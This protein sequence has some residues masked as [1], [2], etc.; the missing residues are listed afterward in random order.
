MYR[1]ATSVFAPALAVSHR[2][3][4][5]GG[6]T[7]PNLSCSL[8]R[9]AEPARASVW[10]YTVPKLSCSLPRGA[11]PARANVW[12]YTVS[13]GWRADEGVRPYH[14]LSKVSTGI[15]DLPS[16]DPRRADEERP[17]HALSKVS[18][19]K[20]LGFRVRLVLFLLRGISRLTLEMTTCSLSFIVISTDF[21]G[22]DEERPYLLKPSPWGRDAAVRSTVKTVHR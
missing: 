22:A 6:C 3:R 11:E 17:Y 12:G 18:T 14:A 19:G 20:C 4:V 7:V 15:A 10:G 13:L 21:V 9:G 8:P 5:F 16:G 1:S 2:W